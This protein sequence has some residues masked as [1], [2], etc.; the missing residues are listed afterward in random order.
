[1][2]NYAFKLVGKTSNFRVVLRRFDTTQ[3]VQRSVI[4][5]FLG[6]RP[7]CLYSFPCALASLRWREFS[8]P[9]WATFCAALSPESDGGG[10][11]FPFRH[12]HKPY[13]T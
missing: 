5:R 9:G 1:M 6:F 11:F 12:S 3:D 10:I 7:S 4:G 8:G 2:K 13:Y